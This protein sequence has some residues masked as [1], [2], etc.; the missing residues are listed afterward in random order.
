MSRPLTIYLVLLLALIL[1]GAGCSVITYD[2]AFP[3]L[4]WYW[5]QEA[6]AQ[7]ADKAQQK[8][9]EQQFQTNRPAK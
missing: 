2:R 8:I 6:R 3:K 1:V 9:W 7:R 4:T 5:S